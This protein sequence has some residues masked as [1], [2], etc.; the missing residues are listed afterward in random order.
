MQCLEAKLG[1]TLPYSMTSFSQ[2]TWD[3]LQVHASMA[4]V[5]L[6][7]AALVNQIATGLQE[8]A[9]ISCAVSGTEHKVCPSQTECFVALARCVLSLGGGESTCLAPQCLECQG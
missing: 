3:V 4:N 7:S 5:M 1:P 2:F 6:H 9:N 8:A